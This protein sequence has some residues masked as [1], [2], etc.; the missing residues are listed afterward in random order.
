MLKWTLILTSCIFFCACSQP[1]GKIALIV[2]GEAVDTAECN[3]LI[4]LNRAKIINNIQ[5]QYHAE[6]N[7]DFWTSSYNGT[8]PLQMLKDTVQ[9]QAVMNMVKRILARK[10]GIAAN[11][12]YDDILDRWQKENERR[13]H[14]LQNGQPIYGVKYF[15]VQQ[16]YGYYHSYLENVVRDKLIQGL[17]SSDEE[18]LNNLYEQF[19]K[20][21]FSKRGS[22]KIEKIILQVNKDDQASLVSSFADMK[23]LADRI[24]N[25]K[26][27]KIEA[28]ALGL[29][30]AQQTMMLSFKRA[31]WMNKPLL[32]QTV[33]DL[34]PG[35]IS[36][37]I[38]E[39]DN[40]LLVK[41]VSR[42]MDLHEP[43]ERVKELVKKM[44]ANRIYQKK[45][46]AM[47][48]EAKISIMNEDI[49]QNVRRQ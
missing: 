8:T 13:K 26:D 7:Q 5:N 45:I 6:Y 36:N 33:M 39:S 34:E 1:S 48:A 49:Y 22:T 9:R 18:P 31:E 35:E 47:A 2:E 29:K 46:E 27:A 40:L 11:I 41:C 17:D 38:E 3:L 23:L 16:F 20:T 30:I 15:G 43:F 12:S 14:A 25:G 44:Y 37:V 24:R 4:T 10:M 19:K 42:E 28:G 32:Y 21:T